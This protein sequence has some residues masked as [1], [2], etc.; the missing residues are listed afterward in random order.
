VVS[1]VAASGGRSES[2]TARFFS[3]LV[4]IWW[5]RH[6]TFKKRWCERR[7]ERLMLSSFFC[8]FRM[9]DLLGEMLEDFLCSEIQDTP[10]FFVCCCFSCF[11]SLERISR[12]ISASVDV[13]SLFF[14]CIKIKR[15]ASCA[16]KLVS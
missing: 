5:Q 6:F 1:E 13:S 16:K 11:F 4:Y 2:A 9:S 12:E 15:E 14:L 3:F 10:Q 8:L 7:R